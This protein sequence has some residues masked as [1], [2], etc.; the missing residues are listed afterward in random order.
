MPTCRRRTR[1][2]SSR[3]LPD[4]PATY[5]SLTPED[6]ANLEAARAWV[7]GHFTEAAEGKYEPIDGKLRVIDAILKNGWVDVKE[8]WKLQ[9]LGVALGDALAQKLLLEWVTVDD[10]F[11]QDAALNWPGT[12]VLCY[13]LTMIAKRVEDGEQVDV[14]ALF[15]GAIEIIT[16]GALSGRWL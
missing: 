12:S 2:H 9:A 1:C 14:Y 7:R 15:E 5:R 3:R 11:G 6:L 16:D 13:P 4:P 10:E 8:T